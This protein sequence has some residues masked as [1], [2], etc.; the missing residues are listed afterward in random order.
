MNQV[1]LPA[2]STL[3]KSFEHGMDVNLGS[4]GAPVW[5][6][7]RRISAFAPTFPAVTSDVGTYD[8]LGS[9][10]DDVDSRGFATSFTV[11][12]NRSLATG[13][14]VP[15]VERII[16]ASRG[17]RDGAVLDIRFY[18]KPEIGTPN[19][20]DA[21]RAFVRVDA[22]R[23]NTGNTGAET[24]AVTFTGKGPYTPIANPFT[25][26][27]ETAPI[28]TFVSPEGA[29][30]GELLTITG[31]G[32]HGATAVTI[33][34]DPAEFAPI[35]PGTIVAILPPGDAGAVPVRVTTPGGTSTAYS[36]LRGS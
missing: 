27:D 19:P 35:N 28:I 8:D 20:N 11:Q 14:L 26:W 31:T 6:P 16:A 3:G 22:T 10:N 4:Y 24:Y 9:P 36:F 12:G 33:D 13:L 29:P 1:P 7:I 2:G 34:G 32:L 30:D 18:H 5:Q 23:Q 15:E 21:G 25:G 17:T